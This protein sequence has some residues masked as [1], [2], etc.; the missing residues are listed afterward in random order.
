VPELDLIRYSNPSKFF[1]WIIAL[2]VILMLSLSFYLDDVAKQYQVQAYMIHKSFG[3][4]I[5][6]LML[7]RILWIVKRGKPPLPATVPLW[8]Q[9]LARLIQY[10]LYILLI[11]MPLSGLILSVAAG[12]SPSF[13][14]LFTVTLPIPASDITAGIFGQVHLIVAW[15]LILLISL[16]ILGA[17]K[18]YF[19]DRDEVLQAMLPGQKP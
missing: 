6:A 13:F 10:S 11:I 3:L 2:L 9:R 7:I 15:I 5:L 14:G 1:H 16:H 17:L 19:I 8:Q 12:R 18:H 4:T